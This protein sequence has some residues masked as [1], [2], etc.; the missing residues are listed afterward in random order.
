MKIHGKEYTEVKD[1][2]PQLLER[3]PRACIQTSLVK[4]SEDFSKVI[5]R[6]EIFPNETPDD[7]RVFSGW[8]YEEKVDTS[9]SEVNFSSWV[10][11]AETSAIG[12]ALANMNIGV[13]VGGAVVR[14]SAEEM[15][16]V[17]RAQ[18]ASSTSPTSAPVKK[19]SGSYTEVCTKIKE[20][21]KRQH[22]HD[23]FWLQMLEN[24]KAKHP[25]EVKAGDR[26]QFM[27]ACDEFLA[28]SKEWL[29]EYGTDS[30]KFLA[31]DKRK[32]FETKLDKLSL[33]A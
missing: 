19:P 2:I 28:K 25:L 6:C 18:S 10:E 7:K 14:P 31:D 26:L 21:F 1:R 20:E 17:E 16:K 11:N 12:R 24:R 33:L 27:D 5:F 13:T 9:S 30:A 4:H 8:A 15:Q 22:G 29:A 32:E 23:K 3:Y